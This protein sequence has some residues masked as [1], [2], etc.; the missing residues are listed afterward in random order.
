MKKF[1]VNPFNLIS[2]AYI[3]KHLTEAGFKD[4][5]LQYVGGDLMLWFNNEHDELTIELLGGSDYIMRE[6]R[7]NTAR[8]YD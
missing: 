8:Y 3:D 4:Y 5:N 7:K 1:L 2:L 6:W